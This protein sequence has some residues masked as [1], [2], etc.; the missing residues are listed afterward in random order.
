VNSELEDQTLYRIQTR[1]R[2]SDLTVTLPLTLPSPWLAFLKRLAGG[3]LSMTLLIRPESLG[4]IVEEDI[5]ALQLAKIAL[6][7]NIRGS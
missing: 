1:H 3:M 7:G 5:L 6:L 2:R 4:V